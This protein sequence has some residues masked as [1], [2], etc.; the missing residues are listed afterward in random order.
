VALFKHHAE[1]NRAKSATASRPIYD[2]VEV[3]EIRRAGS[4]DFGVYPATSFCDWVTDPRPASRGMPSGSR[5]SIASS[6][7][8]PRRPSPAR[9]S[10]MCR[11]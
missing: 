1:I 7:S 11:S 9:R 8:R 4:R 2:D 5:G 6:R 3:V 10:R